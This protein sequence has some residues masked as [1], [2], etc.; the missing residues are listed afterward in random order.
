VTQEP[1]KGRENVM[2]H[3]PRIMGRTVKAKVSKS[4]NVS[5]SDADWVRHGFSCCCYI[6]T[7]AFGQQDYGYRF[8]LL[9]IIVNYF[10][11]NFDFYR[12]PI[13]ID[14]NRRNKTINTD[15]IE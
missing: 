1:I 6:S 9:I 15:D 7:F 8:C 10:F 2:I 4:V 12:S 3:N 11:C 13:S 5:C 14:M